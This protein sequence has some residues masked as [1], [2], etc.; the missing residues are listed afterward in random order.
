[1]NIASFEEEAGVQGAVPGAVEAAI[2]FTP[3]PATHCRGHSVT[4]VLP[5]H[6][7]SPGAMQCMTCHY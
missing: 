2:L 4:A 1:M 6:R 5:Q 7:P 3:V